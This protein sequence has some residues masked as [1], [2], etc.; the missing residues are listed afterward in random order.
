MKKPI[1]TFALLA[2]VI[3]MPFVAAE[4]LIA[5][6]GSEP[7][8]QGFEKINYECGP[9]DIICNRPKMDI[10]FVIDSTGSMHDEIRTI[11]EHLINV[12]ESLESGYPRPDVRIGVVVYRDYPDQEKE[13]L[14]KKLDL[15][16][17]PKKAADFIK[18]IDAY[19]G[20]D[21]EEAVETGLN[22]AI[23]KLTWRS[24]ARKIMLLVGDAPPR[25]YPYYGNYGNSPEYY[26]EYE[27]IPEFV[28]D[29]S[30]KDAIKDAL[31][32]QIVIYT[33]SGS[34]M[35]DRGIE[36]W[37]EIARKTGGSY[38]P[39]IYTVM[40]VDKY[41]EE[42]SIPPEYLAEAKA[43]KDYDA[44]TNSIVTNNIGGFAKIVLR[45]EAESAGVNYENPFDEITGKATIEN[46]TIFTDFWQT[47]KNLFSF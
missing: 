41:Y 15:T 40:D 16:N 7:I 45:Q 13:Y 1:A 43:S 33:A 29:Y 10:V 11:K 22:V 6:M 32:K 20:G 27:N 8:E 46:T 5:K 14:Y 28:R 3:L 18:G 36:I 21:Y 2:L 25:D 38:I 26:E 30:Y 23:N 19:G 39:L 9:N 44:A 31:N 17:N 4:E 34:G 37:K 47:I 42:E 24:N 35:N 12:V